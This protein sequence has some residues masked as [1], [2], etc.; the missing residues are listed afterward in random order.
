MSNVAKARLCSHFLSKC[1]Q[2]PSAIIC[3]LDLRSDRQ[4]RLDEWLKREVRSFKSGKTLNE[5]IREICTQTGWKRWD[6]SFPITLHEFPIIGNFFCETHEDDWERHRSPP[7]LSPTLS[8]LKNRVEVLDEVFRRMK[9]NRRELD[10]G[11]C[12][13]LLHGFDSKCGKEDADAIIENLDLKS[14]RTSRL[15]A[16]MAGHKLAAPFSRCKTLVSWYDDAFTGLDLSHY[17]G[18]FGSH[19]SSSKFATKVLGTYFSREPVK[20]LE[21]SWKE[22]KENIMLMA[23][24][25]E[26]CSLLQT[27]DARS[28]EAKLRLFYHLSECKS[29][30][31]TAEEIVS[32]LDLH[33]DRVARLD[34]WLLDEARLNAFPSTTHVRAFLNSLSSSSCESGQNPIAG[35]F[36]M[37]T[38][39]GQ[40]QSSIEPR[41]SAMQSMLTCLDGILALCPALS[42][43]A[44][45]RLCAGL[46][47]KSEH[48]KSLASDSAFLPS[49]PK[50]IEDLDL[51]DDRVARM[52]AWL[53]Q[54]SEEGA[55]G[56]LAFKTSS[57]VRVHRSSR[58]CFFRM[59]AGNSRLSL[60]SVF[61][62][63]NDTDRGVDR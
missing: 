63:S 6:G 40:P 33:G 15:N 14:N 19:P 61:H 27:R 51:R 26:C 52:D 57:E 45:Q 12:R 50:I 42:A 38:T 47:R 13:R 20:S 4:A 49:L 36:F 8:E 58:V 44:K 2:S 35:D 28:R 48:R 1:S 22:I 9:I 25:V 21:I 3:D 41:F 59:I 5:F 24:V 16:W 56:Q 39:P 34:A 54:S 10:E 11:A 23:K 37:S 30:K 7:L 17:N 46:G 55:R 32:D 18:Y 43:S 29:D 31:L 60:L 53:K 62:P